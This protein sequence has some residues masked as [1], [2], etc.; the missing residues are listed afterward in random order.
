[1]NQLHIGTAAT[2][3]EAEDFLPEAMDVDDQ[4]AW[5]A[6]NK[7]KNITVPSLLALVDNIHADTIGGQSLSHH[8]FW[9][10]TKSLGGQNIYTLTIYRHK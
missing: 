5:I 6:G 10:G 9:A 1:V 2:V 4:C 7:Q 3:M 8:Y